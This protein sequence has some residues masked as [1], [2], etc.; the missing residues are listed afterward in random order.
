M[1]RA[2]RTFAA[3]I[4]IYTQQRKLIC[5]EEVPKTFKASDMKRLLMENFAGNTIKTSIDIL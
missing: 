4:L 2:G 3:D 1:E 5:L